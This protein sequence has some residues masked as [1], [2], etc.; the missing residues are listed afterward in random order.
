[1]KLHFWVSSKIYVV[2]IL[3]TALIG[4]IDFILEFN[5]KNYLLLKHADRFVYLVIYV[6]EVLSLI[7]FLCV[8][9]S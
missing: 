7:Y 6:E 8:V 9:Y 1:M 5:V 3:C 4:S 2:I